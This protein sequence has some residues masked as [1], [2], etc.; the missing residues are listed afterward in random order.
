MSNSDEKCMVVDRYVS[1]KD[2]SSML[3][4]QCNIFTPNERK[5]KEDAFAKT[6]RGSKIYLKELGL[7]SEKMGD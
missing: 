1:I 7:A 2:I 6:I 5:G 3:E 4:E